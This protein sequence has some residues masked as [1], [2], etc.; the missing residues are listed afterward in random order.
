MVPYYGL[1]T[2]DWSNQQRIRRMD[3]TLSRSITEIKAESNKF[4]L[5]PSVILR[6]T[7]IPYC[8]YKGILTTSFA[9]ISLQLFFLG[10]NYK[11]VKFV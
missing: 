2:V 7:L 5:G 9:I 6:Y 10:I 11:N 1:H 8:P 4:G 3:Q